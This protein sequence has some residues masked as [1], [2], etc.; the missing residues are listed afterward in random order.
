V[1]EL[2]RLHESGSY[3]LIVLDTPPAA[4]ALDFVRAPEQ[5]DRLLDPEIS[6]GSRDPTLRRVARL[7]PA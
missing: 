4:H 5:I 1:E 3:D 7:E 2:C 6:A